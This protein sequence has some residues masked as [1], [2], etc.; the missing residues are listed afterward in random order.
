[1]ARTSSKMISHPGKATSVKVTAHERRRP[2][3]NAVGPDR[4]TAQRTTDLLAEN[5]FGAGTTAFDE[6]DAP[7]ITGGL[8]GEPKVNHLK[9]AVGLLNRRR[10]V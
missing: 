4:S 8:A 5:A 3:R 9:A 10:H 2:T 1:V 7:A 6:Q